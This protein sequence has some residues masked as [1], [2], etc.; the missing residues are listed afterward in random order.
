MKKIMIT[1][2]IVAITSLSSV[3]AAAPGTFK[4]MTG[5]DYS[6][7]KYGGSQSTDMLYIPITGRYETGRW[8]FKLTVP[9]LRVTGPGNVVRGVGTLKTITTATRTTESGLGDVVAGATYSAYTGT[10]T[11]PMF[12]DLTGKVKFGTADETKGLG[13]GKNDYAVQVD[14]Y[15][16]LGKL[17]PFGTIGYDAL[18]NPTGSTLNNVFYGSLGGSYRF[19]AKTSGGL[20]FSL[21][22]KASVT[23]AP[24][25]DMMAFVSHKLDKKWKTQV[26]LDKGYTDGSP[27]WEG[28][29][30]ISYAF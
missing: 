23:G 8:L 29:A 14:V 13:T 6:S 11:H 19:T 12:I 17:T 4:L 25:R 3:A 21:R 22:Q 26:Y 28:G 30:T 2:V 1:G 9:Y 15:Q 27:N 5:F 16:S 10:G 7:G 18:G 24:Q 20:L